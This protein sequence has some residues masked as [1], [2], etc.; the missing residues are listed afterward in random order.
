M[1][2]VQDAVRHPHPDI[3]PPGEVP[4]PDGHRWVAINDDDGDIWMFDVTYLLSRHHCIY[5]KGC[6]GIDVEPDHTE[7]LGCCVHGAYFVDSDDLKD[8]FTHVRRLTDDDWQFKS[9]ADRRTKG[10]GKKASTHGAFVQLETGE[11][12]TRVHNDACIFLNRHDHPGGAGCAL[13]STALRNGERPMDWKPDVC[14]QVPIRMDVHTDDNERDTVFI[15][16]W[17]RHDWGGGGADFH[18]WCEEEPEAYT[19]PQPVY[20]TSKDELIGFVGHDIYQALADKLDELQ[21]QTVTP[22]HI[23]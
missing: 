16:G 19:A 2:S 7:T 21:N 4:E 8:T 23:G 13:H 22:V 20:V 12:T 17:E 9:V 5:G 18:W 14:W 10:K 1:T 6:P 15:R 3:T 11:W